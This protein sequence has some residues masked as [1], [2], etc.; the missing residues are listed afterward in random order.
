MGGVA[1]G[2]ARPAVAS[3]FASHEEFLGKTV[4]LSTN[5][6]TPELSAS[7]ATIQVAPTA[8]TFHT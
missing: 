1:F 6:I 7:V 3:V 5:M 4:G 2:D 8:L